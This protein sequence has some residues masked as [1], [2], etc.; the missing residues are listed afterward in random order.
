MKRQPP[1]SKEFDRPDDM[2]GFP[3][4]RR[5]LKQVRAWWEGQEFKSAST[6]MPEWKK[7]YIPDLECA[8]EYSPPPEAFPF[9]KI[10]AMSLFRPLTSVGRAGDKYLAGA[11][12]FL[13]KM[14][15]VYPGWGLRIYHDASLADDP[16]PK[17]VAFVEEARSFKDTKTHSRDEGHGPHIQLVKFYCPAFREPDAPHYHQHMFSA[18][19]RF[20]AWFDPNVDVVA[21]RDIDYTPN[22]EDFETLENFVRTGK[23]LGYYAIYPSPIAWLRCIKPWPEGYPPI[24]AG[25]WM[26]RTNR[27]NYW[28]EILHLATSPEILACLDS[29]STSETVGKGYGTDEVTLNLVLQRHYRPDDFV[30]Y[31]TFNLS[32]ALLRTAGGDPYASV[33]AAPRVDESKVTWDDLPLC[34]AIADMVEDYLKRSSVPIPP[35]IIWHIAPLTLYCRAS[36]HW[37]GLRNLIAKIGEEAGKPAVVAPLVTFINDFANLGVIGALNKYAEM[38]IRTNDTRG[39]QFVLLTV[40]MAK[41]L[42]AFPPGELE[43]LETAL[44]ANLTPEQFTETATQMER[45]WNLVS[46]AMAVG[47]SRGKK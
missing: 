12:Q 23:P 9:K 40:L 28:P 42:D 7:Y 8:L 5:G 26:A 25:S 10:V 29:L 43:R 1:P 34:G 33:G 18:M 15:E 2:L 19:S 11:R 38:Y 47:R 3:I 20:L 17:W 16:D 14:R 45:A 35:V 6:A 37:A 31:G 21:F 46:G 24:A 30:R 22:Y 13:L 39:I 32:T 27:D 41:H 36:L 4:L 44:V